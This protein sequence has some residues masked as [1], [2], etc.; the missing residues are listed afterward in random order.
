MPSAFSQLRVSPKT[1]QQINTRLVIAGFRNHANDII[2]I[3]RIHQAKHSAI[4]PRR[5][6]DLPALAQ[7]DIHLRRSN[8]VRG[9]G[10]YLDE[11]KRSAIVSDQINLSVD[12]HIPRVTSNRQAEICRHDPVTRA[13]EV[14]AGQG[15]AL[16]A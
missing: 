13:L 12:N 16:L 10:F 6:R 11:A 1:F 5:A 3:R 7:I 4:S 14:L 9:S 15:L 8:L 2:S